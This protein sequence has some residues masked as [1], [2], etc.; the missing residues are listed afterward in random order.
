MFGRPS[1]KTNV[2]GKFKPLTVYRYCPVLNSFTLRLH[3]NMQ[4]LSSNVANAKK[5]E[6]KSRKQIEA[7]KEIG[8]TNRKRK[9]FCVKLVVLC[10]YARQPP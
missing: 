1:L 2:N 9:N 8:K 7:G 4:Q 6:E 5:K 10:P 3:F